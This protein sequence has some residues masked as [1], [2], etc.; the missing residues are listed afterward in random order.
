MGLGILALRRNRR[1]MAKMENEAALELVGRKSRRAEIFALPF[2]SARTPLPRGARSLHESIEGGGG[3][4][5]L[6]WD[7]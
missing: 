1:K 4:R 5:V 7:R 2:R 3:R 6:S